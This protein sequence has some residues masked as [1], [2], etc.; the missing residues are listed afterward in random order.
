MPNASPA[1]PARIHPAKRLAGLLVLKTQGALTWVGEKVG[2]EWLIYNPLVHLGFTRAAKRNAPIVASTL[3]EVFTDVRTIVDVGCGPGLYVRQFV[4]TGFNAIG[5]EYSPKLRR[6]GEKRGV[7]ILPFDVSIPT[8]HPPGA[9]FDL[10]VSFEVGEHISPALADAFVNYFRGLAKRVVFSAAHPGQG[11]TAHINEQPREY[12]IE[13]FEKI[14]F[15]YDPET[16]SVI[17]S[18]FTEKDAHWY[19]PKNVSVFVAS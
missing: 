5:V 4:H 9:P 16:T 18:K 10:A 8:P 6:S 17:A 11:G 3:R 19:L 12:W 2:S 7:Q 15:K 1:S 14:G 13:K